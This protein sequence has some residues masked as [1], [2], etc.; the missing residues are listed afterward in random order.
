MTYLLLCPW[1]EEEAQF[2]GELDEELT[3]RGCGIRIS[4]ATES[5]EMDLAL[6]TAA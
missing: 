6:P 1:C 5:A 3:C 4:L 2:D